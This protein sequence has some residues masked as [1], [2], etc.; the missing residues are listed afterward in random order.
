MLKPEVVADV[1]IARESFLDVI[2]EAK[3]ILMEHWEE[4]AT[5]LDVPLEPDYA[6]Y[7]AIDKQGLLA[8][9]TVR[10]RGELVGYSVY[11]VRRHLHY[12]ITVATNDIIMIRK[13]YRNFG[14]GSAL[15]SF[16]ELDLKD[17]GVD[18]IYTS[19]KLSHPE[20]SLLLELRGHKEVDRSFS[21]RL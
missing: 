4:L 9:Y 18:V 16:I 6:A 8:I 1:K 3:P 7:E 19:A 17:R 12:K 14:L 15:F 10:A 5:Y 11:F 13:H 20:L 2:E 21:L